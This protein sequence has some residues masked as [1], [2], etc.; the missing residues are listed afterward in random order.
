MNYRD[1]PTWQ[2][3]QARYMEPGPDLSPA[4]AYHARTEAIQ[5]MYE[6]ETVAAT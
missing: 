6:I 5:V 1:D 3:A 4:E 2:A